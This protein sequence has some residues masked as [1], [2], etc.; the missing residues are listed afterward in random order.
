MISDCLLPSP[1]LLLFSG[2]QVGHCYMH[3]PLKTPA[4]KVLGQK[5]IFRL[6][7]PAVS[8]APYQLLIQGGVIVHRVVGM[9]QLQSR[10]QTL[11]QAV[12]VSGSMN[13]KAILL[14]MLT[15]MGLAADSCPPFSRAHSLLQTV[16]RTEA[17]EKRGREFNCRC[18]K[19]REG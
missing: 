3:S 18:R 17:E 9:H 7:T 4:L 14:R 16:T 5:G 19:Q 13:W 8:R 6:Q 10:Q 1:A 2:T 12:T 15:M 11:C